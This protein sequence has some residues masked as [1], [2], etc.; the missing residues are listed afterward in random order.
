MY[1]L[2][3]SQFCGLSFIKTN[4]GKFIARHEKI[5]RSINQLYGYYL[6]EK[7][8]QNLYIKEKMCDKSENIEG[9]HLEHKGTRGKDGELYPSGELNEM[10][11]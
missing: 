9:W 1:I 7:K 3:F 8:T 6:E 11:P 5:L 4:L 2:Q 10:G